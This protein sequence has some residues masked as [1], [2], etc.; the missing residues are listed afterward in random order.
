M[1]KSLILSLAA[2]MFV[3]NPAAWA[4]GPVNVDAKGV[5]VKGYDV[6]NYF[7]KNTAVK[8]SQQYSTQWDGATWYFQN[9]QNRELFELN[10]K[11]Y[12]PEYGGYCA[13]GV[14]QNAKADIDPEAF[15][16][17]K[18]HL[19]LNVNSQVKRYWESNKEMN[20]NTADANWQSLKNNR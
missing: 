15:S 3:V 16:V 20:I 14:T 6:V 18:D 9:E 5:A 8:G 19:Y 2:F 17:Y 10:P 13:Y 12:A 4:M 7:L 11:Y 1:R